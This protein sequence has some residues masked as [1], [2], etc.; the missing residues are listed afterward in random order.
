MIWRIIII[1]LACLV[2]H[3]A[4]F[5][6]DI[7]FGQSAA[8][9]NNGSSC[10]NQ[11]SAAAFNTAG[12]WGAG[13]GKV[14]AGDTV[15]LCGTI[16]GRLNVQASGNAGNV[17]TITA[18]AGGATL[19]MQST[20]NFVAF[21]FNAFQ[22]ITVDGLTGDAR[23]GN[24]TYPFRVI[25]LAPG[26]TDSTP[27]FA[28]YAN[29]GGEGHLAI[30][31]IEIT[32]S[33]GS[34]SLTNQEGGVYLQVAAVGDVEFSYNWIHGVNA[35]TKLNTTG[36]ACW[37][38]TGT[39]SYT[40]GCNIHHNL[41]QYMA[42]DGIRAGS[43]ASLH[44][45]DLTG[46]DGS[47]HSD[48]LLCQSGNYCAIYNNYVYSSADQNIYINNLDNSYRGHLRIY[49]NV[50]NS[51]PGFGIVLDA[52]G[53]ASSV[54]DDV[55]IAHNTFY[56]QSASALRV[57]NRGQVTNLAMLNNIFGTTSDISYRS[58]ELTANTTI[59]NS[60]SWDYNVY[61]TAS[62]NYPQIAVWGAS[63]YTRAQLQ[64]VSPARET[65][66]AVGIPTY[67]NAGANDFHLA[68]GDTLAKNTGVNL[69]APY[70]FLT[71]DKD[72]LSR[73]QGS[74]WDIGAYEFDQG[75]SGQS[76]NPPGA[77]YT[78]GNRASTGIR[79]LAHAGQRPVR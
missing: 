1:S 53:G 42:H 75:G 45:N 4:A 51:D 74:A 28:F 29:T 55:V 67:V 36:L 72:G 27:S 39:T 69:S 43:N 44:D 9:A 66:G 57:V 15:Y 25:N 61:S 32:G 10:A 8:G 37:S 46:V 70:S 11:L 54:L 33:G 5:A 49:N 31:H 62:A 79:P 26:V 14:S 48:S 41:I 24:T 64:A 47:G 35:G 50:I 20:S 30:R 73:P 52:E 13:A 19:D 78:S 60:S 34:S 17:I 12:N 76:P 18:A 40:D 38:A 77:S 16:T 3:S 63:Q 21:S 22:Y 58:V 56:T 2:Y 71:A 23:A 59:M 6:E 65:H 68:S 7:Y